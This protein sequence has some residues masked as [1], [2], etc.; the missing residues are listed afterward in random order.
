M[1]NLVVNIINEI[2]V[3]KVIHLVVVMDM[4]VLSLG[5]GWV[6]ELFTRIAAVLF[7]QNIIVTPANAARRNSAAFQCS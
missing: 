4:V 3:R 2:H 5:E 1:L 6:Q 7:P